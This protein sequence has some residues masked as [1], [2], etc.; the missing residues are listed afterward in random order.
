MIS[1]KLGSFSKGEERRE[2]ER[3]KGKKMTA[4]KILEKLI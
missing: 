1:E 4:V 2:V 3:E